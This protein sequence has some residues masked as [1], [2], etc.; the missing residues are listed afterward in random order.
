[1]TIFSDAEI[2]RKKKSIV[3]LKGLLVHEDRMD[4]RETLEE[5]IDATRAAIGTMKA[6]NETE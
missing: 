5:M 6:V 3:F 4:V 2:E 1:M